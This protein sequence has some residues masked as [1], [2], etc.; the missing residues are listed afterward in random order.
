MP[1]VYLELMKDLDY[2]APEVPRH[3][4]VKDLDTSPWPG[5]V[6]AII[7]VEETT[8]DHLGRPQRLRVT[9]EAG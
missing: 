3:R 6:E 5:T 4:F 7:D 8:W 9:L 2:P 1:S